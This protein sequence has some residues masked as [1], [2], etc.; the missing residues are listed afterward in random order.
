MV[1][2]NVEVAGPGGLEPRKVGGD[3]G[4]KKGRTGHFI[5]LQAPITISMRMRRTGATH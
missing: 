3:R 2:D 4:L 5:G 1:Q